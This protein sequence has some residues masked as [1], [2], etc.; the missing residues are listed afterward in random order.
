M[1]RAGP[2]GLAVAHALR[3]LAT[4]I[5]PEAL[6]TQ[7]IDFRTLLLYYMVAIAI[8]TMP[9]ARRKIHLHESAPQRRSLCIIWFYLPLAYIFRA[10]TDLH[11]T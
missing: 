4:V 2:G 11:P 5:G 1:A 6:V 3:W 10:E 9:T 8:T 7:P